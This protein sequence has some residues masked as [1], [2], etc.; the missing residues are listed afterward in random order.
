M[1][2]TSQDKKVD[3][4]SMREQTLNPLHGVTSMIQGQVVGGRLLLQSPSNDF[5]FTIND[6]QCCMNIG[7][8][9]EIMNSFTRVLTAT[10]AI[11]R[12]FVF[13]QYS[14]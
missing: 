13:L 10:Q 6:S 9:A 2:L 7:I 4:S 8:N 5:V 3:G 12:C 14:V 1:A 11:L